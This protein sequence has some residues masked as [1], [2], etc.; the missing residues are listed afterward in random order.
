MEGSKPLPGKMAL[1]RSAHIGE[2]QAV[3]WHRLLPVA[4]PAR[5]AHLESALAEG[6]GGNIG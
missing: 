6:G 5:S 3:S 1:I 4:H 2:T